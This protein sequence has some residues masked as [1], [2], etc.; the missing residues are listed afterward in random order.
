[1]IEQYQFH[2]QHE[3]VNKTV[4]YFPALVT[5]LMALQKEE[6]K[7]AKWVLLKEASKYLTFKEARS[8]CQQLIHKF[9]I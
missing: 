6:I 1:L 9:N 4:K 5:G 3:I 7:D 8:M 2:R